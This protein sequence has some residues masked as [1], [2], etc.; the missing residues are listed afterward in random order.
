MP[1]L[2]T[3]CY[4]NLY[5]IRPLDR[6]YGESSTN[7]RSPGKIRMK[8]IRIFPDTYA[9]TLCPF[10]SS[11]ENDALGNDSLIVPSTSMTSFSRLLVMDFQEISSIDVN[12]SVPF[13]VIAIV[14]SKWADNLP[15]AVT[16]VHPSDS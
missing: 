3:M 14:S 11:T 5:V 4:L 12:T 1:D 10:A 16:T 8:C 13:S 9:R 6:S 2:T 7:T 15:S